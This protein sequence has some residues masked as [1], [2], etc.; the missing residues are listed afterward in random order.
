M[1]NFAKRFGE[2]DYIDHAQ[3]SLHSS[4]ITNQ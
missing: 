1:K 3:I 4:S 2:I